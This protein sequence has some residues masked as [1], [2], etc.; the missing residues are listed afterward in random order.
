V[1]GRWYGRRTRAEEVHSIDIREWKREGLLEPGSM[2]AIELMRNGGPAGSIKVIVR[3]QG[4]VFLLIGSGSI[5][6][7]IRYTRIYRGSSNIRPWFKCPGCKR[8]CALLYWPRW[9]CRKCSNLAYLSELECK[10]FRGQRRVQKIQARL[11]GDGSYIGDF[12]D[13]PPRMHW[14]TYQRWYE[15]HQ[16]AYERSLGGATLIAERLLRRYR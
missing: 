14:K 15:K 8:R 13:K 7:D 5:I 9:T 11:G 1:R 2:F 6:I 4:T 16:A 12:P 10:G 3:D